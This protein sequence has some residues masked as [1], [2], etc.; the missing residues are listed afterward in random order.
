MIKN[1]K[2]GNSVNNRHGIV[3][4]GT[5]LRLLKYVFS[6]YKGRMI[7]TCLCT[8]AG[9]MGSVI[10]S[11][12]VRRIVDDVVVPGL[13]VGLAGVYKELIGI[14]VSMA[15]LYLISVFCVF[16]QT[17][18]MAEITQGTLRNL[19]DDM[20]E[21]MEK[22]PVK[23]F[24]THPHGDI[25]STY[26]N[27][28]DAIREL[29][30]RCIP[31]FIQSFFS[32]IALFT[33][34]LTFSVY[35]T[36]SVILFLFL[37]LK[38]IRKIGTKSVTYMMAQQKSLAEEE[39][40]IEE[41]MEG[42]RVIKVFC[43]QDESKKDF[44]AVNDKL[45]QDSTRANK[46]ANILAPITNNM[47]N[48]LY[49]FVALAGSLLV[50]FKVGN[51]SLSGMSTISIGIVISFLGMVRALSQTIGQIT[52]QINMITM[53]MA[54]ASR[55]FSL[56]DEETEK[57]NGYVTLVCAKYD[58]NGNI[59]ET[60]QRT[61]LWAWKHPHQADG[62]VTYTPLKGDIVM[63]NVEFG[64]NEGTQV[65][66]DISLYAKPG[67]KIAFVGA[68]GAGKTTI[69]NLLNRFYDIPD[70]K[71]RYDGININKIKK[72]DLRKSL[73]IVLQDVNLFSGTVFDNI[74][75]G[76]TDATDE[77][78]IRAAKLANAHSFITR[79]PE[80]YNTVL[81]ANASN[82]SQGQR[83]LL[84]IARV[85]V[86]DPPVMVLDEATSSIDT[87]TEAMVQEG[88]DNLMKGRTVFVIAHRLSTIRNSNAIM[89][90]DHGRI[91]ERGDHEDLINQKGL[92][93]RLYTGAFELK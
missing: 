19:R 54:G 34:M 14:I 26:T 91:I 79:L 92:Y 50:Y 73:G 84:S 69:T 76:R 38:V 53:G 30:G 11:V 24:D 17:R 8:I 72:P 37:T 36:A 62:S 57:D 10:T 60:D 52:Q 67:Q 12:F 56:M 93:Y 85:A 9:A 58:E 40:F 33:M 25:M 74:R 86:A 78:C 2:Q 68:T 23:Y 82:L 77:D 49:V 71:I 88:M 80:G 21:K 3:K 81:S 55:V 39:G 35:M 83:Q 42:Q 27:D 15:A 5:M 16:I 48:I 1:L 13:S 7:V 18:F 43:H 65:L 89:V 6:N 51:I 32:I 90:L 29:I 4:K 20:F 22:L 45:K 31:S 63:E 87:R 46:F 66:F 28:T 75:Y 61:D 59:T 70:G 41:M 47:G 64:Y 44:D